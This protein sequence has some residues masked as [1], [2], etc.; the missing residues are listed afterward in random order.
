MLGRQ[1]VAP[2]LIGH[3]DGELCVGC[4]VILSGAEAVQ[5]ADRGAH[6]SAAPAMKKSCLRL[7]MWISMLLVIS[8]QGF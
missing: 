8:I 4:H 3:L 5:A 6:P 1:R 2:L 7:G